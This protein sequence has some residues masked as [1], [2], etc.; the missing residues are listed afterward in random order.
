MLII[1]DTSCPTIKKPSPQATP[2][3]INPAKSPSRIKPKI[4]DSSISANP[5]YPSSPSKRIY[6]PTKTGYRSPIKAKNRSPT[7]QI[8]LNK[9]KSIHDLISEKKAKSN[10]TSPKHDSIQKGNSH[11]NNLT[12][13][14]F[15][16]TSD[17]SLDITNIV[18]NLKE[19]IEKEEAE[20]RH[21]QR[22]AFLNNRI[23]TCC[24]KIKNH[25]YL[26]HFLDENDDKYWKRNHVYQTF[27]DL[28]ID[29]KFWFKRE[30]TTKYLITAWILLILIL[31]RL[32]Y[33]VTDHLEDNQ[34][35]AL[36]S[37]LLIIFIGFGLCGILGGVLLLKRCCMD[38]PRKRLMIEQECGIDIAH[39]NRNRLSML[40]Q[41]D[42]ENDD[43]YPSKKTK[44]SYER[45]LKQKAYSRQALPNFYPGDFKLLGDQFV[46]KD[47]FQTVNNIR[48]EIHRLD[49]IMMRMDTERKEKCSRTNYCKHEHHQSDFLDWGWV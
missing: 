33:E 41:S 19:R 20:E 48:D 39:A 6:S 18:K 46:F 29:V 38:D 12:N 26:S 34:N 22:Y 23:Q 30:E 36:I 14:I 43:D 37:L 15:L 11:S 25:H 1:E 4:R 35:L 3:K 21:K 40:N 17:N 49:H 28:Y 47:K 2:R 42:S 10:R 24:D 5:K 7:Q 31:T 13:S 16:N 27:K 9:Q 32:L 8:N 45:Y 44:M